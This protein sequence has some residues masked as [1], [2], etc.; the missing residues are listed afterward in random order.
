MQS[1]EDITRKAK[2]NLAIALTCLSKERQADMVTFYAFCRTIDDIADDSN[3]PDEE[4]HEALNHWQRA[5]ESQQADAENPLQ[6]DTVALLVRYEIN[7]IYL[8]EIIHGCRS[9]IGN[10]QTFG[11]WDELSDYTYKVACCVGLASIKIFGCTHPDS[12]KYAINLGHALQLTNILR[13][14]GYDLDHGNRIYLPHAD[15]VRFQ[16]SERDLIGKVHDGRFISMMEYHA[17]RAEHFYTEAQKYLTAEDAKALKASESMRKI[18]FNILQ[19]MRQDNFQVFS[20]HYKLSKLKKLW[21]L[22]K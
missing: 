6:C 16:Y 4:K 19:K 15:M 22:L 7:P 1:A 12:E 9:D 2:S 10:T 17:Q 11:S 3:L 5:I 21:Y 18:Y 14:V 13:D 20:K 8:L